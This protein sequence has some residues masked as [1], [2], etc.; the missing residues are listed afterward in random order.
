MGVQGVILKPDNSVLLIR[1]GYRPGWH[2]PGGG[3]E[4]RESVMSA[5]KRELTEEAGIAL[6]AEPELF[7]LYCHEPVF[8]GD[9]IALFVARSW[10]QTH[11]PK[12]NAEI[13]EQGFFRL[14]AL[15]E[16]TH[17][18]TRSRLIEVLQSGARSDM[19]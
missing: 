7:G 1:H 11:V 9:H 5:L 18:S 12:P 2:F 8:P 3:V 17:P 14:E 6:E 15:P 13:A 16:G 4:K 10:T 19:W